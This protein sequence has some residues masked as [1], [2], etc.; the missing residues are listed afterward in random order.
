[1]FSEI[2]FEYLR[3]IWVTGLARSIVVKRLTK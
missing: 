2:Q 1:M 3:Q